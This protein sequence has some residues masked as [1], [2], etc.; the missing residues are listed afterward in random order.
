MSVI[1]YDIN[2]KDSG[3]LPHQMNTESEE[4][5]MKKLLC[6]CLSLCLLLGCV[7]ALAEVEQPK[8]YPKGVISWII[9]SSAGGAADTF[10]RALG[11]AGL[12]G[13][14]VV[15]NIS[16]GSQSIGMSECFT[17][18]AD[19][20]TLITLSTT[21]LI[22]MPLTSEVIY[23]ADDFR[24]LTKLAN[25]S[26]GVAVTRPD[27]E[28]ETADQLWD[29]LNGDR[30][31]TVG[32]S[33]IG[34]HSHVEFAHA[35]MQMGKYDKATFVVYKGSNGVM[36]A[37]QNGEVEFGLMDDNYIV[38]YVNNGELRA[39]MTLY[40]DRTPLLPDVKAMAEYG[41]EGL[42]P[43]AGVKIVAVRKD[44]PDDIV[45][46]IKQQVNATILSD[47]YQQFL[48]TSGAGAMT[49]I[50]TEEEITQWVADATASWD[51]VLTEAGLK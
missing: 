50:P 42:A 38:P 27:S 10:T 23:S 37:V 34:G 7:S 14:V 48:I 17:R 46:W 45:E 35:L 25:D 32:V 19:G 49:V 43:L 51:A 33:S 44:T 20:Q 28:L 36:Q 26:V 12:G 13:N 31:Y 29:L 41:I 30:E 24:Y 1:C 3:A 16:G 21:G 6:M 2:N 8:G 40:S 15:E 22:T 39:L 11:N 9:P 4:T 47:E 18:P 5:I